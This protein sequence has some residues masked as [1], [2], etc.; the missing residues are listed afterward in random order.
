MIS[1]LSVLGII[2]L[3]FCIA[4]VIHIHYKKQQTSDLRA[5]GAL[6][7]ALGQQ[8]PI[9]PETVVYAAI[10]IQQNQ[11]SVKTRNKNCEALVS[12]SYTEDTVTYSEVH[13]KSEL[14]DKG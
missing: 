13:I 7:D 8:T 10:N 6:V 4:F 5:N 11:E 2:V 14:K 1:S 12:V 3:I 9:T